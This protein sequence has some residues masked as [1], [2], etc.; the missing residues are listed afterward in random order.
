MKDA[1]NLDRVLSGLKDFQ[2]ATVDYVFKRLYDDA[3]PA[4]RFLVADEVGLGKTIVARG[5]IARMLNH[6]WPKVDR[7]DVLYVCSNQAIASQNVKR[8]QRGLGLDSQAQLDR[9]TLLPISL[10]TLNANKVNFIAFTPGTS[11]NVTTSLGVANERAVLYLMLPDDWKDTGTGAMNLM[12]GGVLDHRAWRQRVKERQADPIEHSILE[13]FRA[14]VNSQPGLKDKFLELAGEF[15]YAT[16]NRSQALRDRRNSLIGELRHLLAHCCLKALEPD[17]IIMDEFQRFTELLDPTSQSGELAKDLFDYSDSAARA[18]V[19]LL[20]ATPYRWLTRSD[21]QD[22]HYEEF[23]KTIRFLDPAREQTVSSLM[24]SYR[25]ALQAVSQ[26]DDSALQLTV[27]KSQIEDQLRGVM[28]RTERLAASSERMGMLSE[29]APKVVPTAAD[30][31][32]FVGLQSASTEVGQGGSLTYWKTAPYPLSFMDD[33]QLKTAVELRLADGTGTVSGAE[34]SGWISKSAI[35][36]YTRIDPGNARLRE[37]QA[38][39][40][41]AGAWRLL[42]IP[43]SAPYYR[44]EGA[45]A[46]PAL[47]SFT[48]RLVFS[49]WRVVPKALSVLLSYEAERQ[50]MTASNPNAHYTR[51]SDRDSALLRFASDNSGPRG[52]PV[53][54][55]M[56]PSDVLAAEIDPVRLT[57]D[58]RDAEGLITADE[59]LA[60]AEAKIETLLTALDGWQQ[61]D[62]REDEAWYW[63][64]PI[65]LDIVRGPDHSKTWWDQNLAAVWRGLDTDDDPDESSFQAHIDAARRVLAREAQL[66]RMPADL[67]RVLAYVGLAAPATAALRSLHQALA[68]ISPDDGVA[69]RDAAANIGWAFRTMFNLPDVQANVRLAAEDDGPYWRQVLKHCVTGGLGAV[70]DEYV[71]VVSEQYASDEED[72]GASSGEIADTVEKALQLRTPNLDVDELVGG[73]KITGFPIRARFARALSDAQPDDKRLQT[74]DQIR[75]A[76]NSPFWPFVLVTTSIGQEGLDFHQYCHAIVHWDLPNNPVDL[77]QREGRIHRYKGHAIRRNIAARHR[78]ALYDERPEDPWARMFASASRDDGSEMSPY[79]VYGGGDRGASIERHVLSYVLSRDVARYRKL[80]GE[81]AVYRLAF[82][83]PNQQDLVDYLLDSYGPEVAGRLADQLRIDLSPPQV[84]RHEQ[85]QPT[86]AI[87]SPN[88][89]S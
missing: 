51:A 50:I 68:P 89:P 20:S 11:F 63:A 15:R 76:F 7:I 32:R 35:E 61:V 81:L 29:R 44:L 5:L 56:Y 80:K 3:P 72:P 82:G 33:Y 83:Q 34:Q 62:D 59:L 10:H 60:A 9:L 30:L 8:L 13:G 39:T 75:T 40:V 70:L 55:L 19:L 21:G 85:P 24:R 78:G 36:T 54:T 64:A 57:A 2:R 47:R 17:L 71:H 41:D 42:W 6:L 58:K 31:H 79:W 18:K 12:Q 77:E 48:K 87:A 69:V 14:E 66:G 84:A 38:Q 37:L 25:L 52:M 67:P 1:P 4:H 65:L 86:E 22:D 28:C 27:I 23:L 49:G 74:Q 46:D 73:Q 53:F 43:P 45:Y 16:N 88:S 26:S